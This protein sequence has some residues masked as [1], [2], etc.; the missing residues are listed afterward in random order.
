VLVPGHITRILGSYFH[1]VCKHGIQTFHHG[2][3]GLRIRTLYTLPCLA[4]ALAEVIGSVLYSKLIFFLRVRSQRSQWEYLTSLCFWCLPPIMD[5]KNFPS[6]LV[7]FFFLNFVSFGCTNSTPD[8]SSPRGYFWVLVAE[9]RLKR[10][11]AFEYFIL[12]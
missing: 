7:K 8:G 3:R 11:Y 12:L 9:H 6:L 5:S 2:D 10:L 4:D 1:V